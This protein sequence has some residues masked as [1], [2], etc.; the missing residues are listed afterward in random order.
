MR[1][2]DFREKIFPI[3]RGLRRIWRAKTTSKAGNVAWRWGDREQ[4]I[5]LSSYTKDGRRYSNAEIHI[6]GAVKGKGR[7][8]MSAGGLGLARKWERVCG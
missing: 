5:G 7:K 8:G 1:A 2:G 4:G 3:V 6:E